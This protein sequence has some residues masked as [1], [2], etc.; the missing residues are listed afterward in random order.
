MTPTRLGIS[1]LIR[2]ASSSVAGL[3]DS[4]FVAAT[5]DESPSV[6]PQPA[7]NGQRNKARDN[8][9]WRMLHRGKTVTWPNGIKPFVALC[10]PFVAA[11]PWL[12]GDSPL[13][14]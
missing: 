8:N 9:G 11:I 6:K 3:D 4:P 2:R 14:C 5:L 10:R 1:L 13:Q 7:T 12:S